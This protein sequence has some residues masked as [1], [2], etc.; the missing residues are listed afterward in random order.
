MLLDLFMVMFFIAVM[1]VP[2]YIAYKRKLKRR[3]ACFWINLLVGWTIIGW[4]P[5]IAWAALTSAVEPGATN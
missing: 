2:T 5:L 4:I 1:F 3:L